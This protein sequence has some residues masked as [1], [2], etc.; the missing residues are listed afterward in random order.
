MKTNVAKKQKPIFVNKKSPEFYE[1]V[2]KQLIR[3]N[4]T[5]QNSLAI[6]VSLIEALKGT[7]D[8]LR[9]LNQMH[10]EKQREAVKASPAK[11]TPYLHITYKK[12]VAV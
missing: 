10:K 9:K 8:D 4:I 5:L 12:G 2:I 3:E 7:V 11:P 6:K 1:G